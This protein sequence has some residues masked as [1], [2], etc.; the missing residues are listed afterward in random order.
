MAIKKEFKGGKAIPE[1]DHV[2]T[3]HEMDLA[4]SKTGKPMLTVKFR[5]AD[6]ATLKSFYVKELP[7]HMKQLKALK[8]ACGLAETADASDLL[9]KQCGIAV[10]LGKPNAEGIQYGQ[11]VGY[12]KA[13]EV[14]H[15]DDGFGAPPDF[16]KTDDIPF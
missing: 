7:F 13:S 5:R 1:G 8:V 11:I 15:T 16:S 3:V 10:E 9:G 12:G 4:N 2:V 6:G 14:D